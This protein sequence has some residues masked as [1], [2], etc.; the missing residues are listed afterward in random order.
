MHLFFLRRYLDFVSMSLCGGLENGG[1]TDEEFK[2]GVVQYS[3]VTFNKNFSCL[4]FLI[5]IIFNT[6]KKKKS[7]Y[8][9]ILNV[10]ICMLYSFLVLH[11]Y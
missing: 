9:I 1:P 11:K 4:C 10:K 6:E 3:E 5:L 7:F 8:K 2:R